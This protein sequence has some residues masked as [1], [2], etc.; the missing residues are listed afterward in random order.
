M[1]KEIL[2]LLIIILVPT[3]IGLGISPGKIDIKFTP[4]LKHDFEITVS[5]TP[6][7]EDR[8]VEIYPYLDLIGK[9]VAPEF[10]NVIILQTTK[11]S[12]TKNEAI[13]TVRATLQFPQGFSKGGMH[14]LRV[15]V[16]PFIEGSAGLAVRAGNEMRILVDVPAQYVD[17][18]YKITPN[19]KEIKKIKIISIDAQTVKSGE[20]STITIKIK[21]ESDVNLN[22]VYATIKIIKNDR[23]QEILQTEKITLSPQ[24]EKSLTA[25]FNTAGQTNEL[26]LEVEVFYD[27]GS[28]IGEGILRLLSKETQNIFEVGKSNKSYVL[29]IFIIILILIAILL[30]LFFLWKRKEER[31]DEEG[32]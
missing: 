32:I 28:V 11:L 26:P 7:P 9:E 21:S 16:T 1:K 3:I 10:Q 2:F 4:N 23:Q 17:D 6:L 13:K 20:D 29:F 22:N 8:I 14:E 25:I 31:K 30:I 18:K 5:N 19:D 12:F 27:A 15:G 24:Q